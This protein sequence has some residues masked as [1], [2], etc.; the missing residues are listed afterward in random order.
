MKRLLTLAALCLSLGTAALAQTVTSA[1][2]L[3]NFQ[4]R[5]AKPDGNPLPNG[6]YTVTFRLYDANVAGTVKWAEQVGSVAVKNGTFA[7]LLGRILP[8]NDAHLNGNTWLEI[9]VNEEEPLFPRQRLVSVA[10]ALKANTVPD[11]AITTAK[12]ADGS[13]TQVKLAAG[14]GGGANGTAGGDLTGTYPN[15]TIANNAVTS[16]KLADASVLSA[17]LA[18]GSVTNEKI[19]SVDWSKITNTPSVTD[20][21]SLLGNNASNPII[22]FLGTTDNQPLL[23]KV[24]NRQILRM[25]YA[26]STTPVSNFTGNNVIGGFWLNSITQ[27]V[28]G[29]TVWG[30]LRERTVD[31]PNQ[32]TELGGTVAGGRSNMAGNGN[33]VIDDAVHPTV[34][35]G[36]FNSARSHNTTVSGGINNHAIGES[37]SVSGGTSNFAYGFGAM[38]PGGIENVA[39]GYTSFAS[40]HRAKAN[41][42]GAF[43]RGDS[44]VA[45]FAST[46]ANQFLIRAGGGVGINVNNPAGHALN[47]NGTAKFSGNITVNGTTY[48]SDA[49]YKTNINPLENPLATI[50][51]MRGVSYDWKRDDFKS[52]NFGA[53]RQIGFI[54]Q[55]LEKVL[56]ELVHTDSKGY[57]SVN[58]SHVVPVLV[59]AVKTLNAKVERLSN[60][61]KK[62]ADLEARIKQLESM[63]ER[64]NA[65]KDAHKQYR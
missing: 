36:A 28:V 8:L 49:R 61:E 39:S 6:T 50:L 9:Q 30:G 25:Q 42:D 21:W 38:I 2:S 47:V 52:M 26:I 20:G 13:V 37:S 12:I 41:H 31:S 16:A 40:G 55:E 35:G 32:V 65:D 33:S 19:T 46:A 4:G 15:P 1:P 62:N 34:G 56:P 59:E 54:A 14:V 27:G 58:Y 51:N 10:Y 45:D 60:A 29:G 23:V 63:M 53:G 64:L 43:V 11:G 5:L 3:L 44:T 48:T 22:H 18:T 7:C 24:N 57:K 17:K